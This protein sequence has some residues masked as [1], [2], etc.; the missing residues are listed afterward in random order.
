MDHVAQP[1]GNP[2]IP[3]AIEPT[4]LAMQQSALL[5]DLL[6]HSAYQTHLMSSIL[7][8]TK[9]LRKWV[10]FFGVL[11][12][13]FIVGWLLFALFWILVLGGAALSASS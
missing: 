9:T 13:L 7:K 12:V 1:P 2:D 5:T 6:R 11:T 10:T 4:Q 3:S 8:E